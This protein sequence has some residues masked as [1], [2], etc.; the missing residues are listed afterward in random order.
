MTHAE[1]LRRWPR[2]SELATAIGASYQAVQQWEIRSAIPHYW[3]DRVADAAKAS[4]IKGITVASL[5][6][7][8]EKAARTKPARRNARK[9]KP[10]QKAIPNG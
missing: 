7:A 9:P 4:S 1:M 3:F 10:E 5:T 6:A 8:A 2:R